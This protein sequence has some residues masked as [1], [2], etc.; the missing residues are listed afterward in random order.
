MS[1]GSTIEKGG[2]LAQAQATLAGLCEGAPTRSTERPT[3]KRILKAFVRARITL[4][5]VEMG[6]AT[7]WHL[8]PLSML[9]E[10]LL[11]YLHLP[12]SLYSALAYNSS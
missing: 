2:G 11:R 1:F 6:T 12:A 4:T 10:Q 9:H 7:C 8:T 3:S 5:Q